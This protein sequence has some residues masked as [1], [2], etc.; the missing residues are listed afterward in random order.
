MNKEYICVHGVLSLK[1]GRL[2]PA[3]AESNLPRG[4]RGKPPVSLK[5]SYFSKKTFT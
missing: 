5:N 1:I 2:D 3:F 4:L